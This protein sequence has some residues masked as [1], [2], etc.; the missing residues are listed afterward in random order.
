[1]AVAPIFFATPFA[2]Q[3]QVSAANANLDGSGTI[4]DIVGVQATELKIETIRA[5]ALVTTTAGMLRFYLHD[6]SATRLFRELPVTANTKSASNPAFEGSLDFSRPED[7][8]IL[9]VGW[10]L[11]ASTEKAEAHNIHVFGGLA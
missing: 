11:Q 9:P 10:K 2:K 5:K 6:G 4:V 3:G 8:L 1:M 7:V